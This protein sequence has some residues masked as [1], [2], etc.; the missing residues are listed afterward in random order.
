MGLKMEKTPG[1]LGENH[2]VGER[3]L[4]HTI[5]TLAMPSNFTMLFQSLLN[6]AAIK[7]FEHSQI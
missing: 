4:N 3:K 2:S 7:N 6:W 5:S 1:T